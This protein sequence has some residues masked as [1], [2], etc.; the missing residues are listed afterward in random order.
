MRRAKSSY[1][2]VTSKQADTLSW[3]GVSHSMASNHLPG[4]LTKLCLTRRPP[5]YLSRSQSI[6]ARAASLED[7][8]LSTTGLSHELPSPP[9]NRL[10]AACPS[11]ADPAAIAEIR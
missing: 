11:D 1:A 3:V 8:T 6:S 10:S 4:S 5:P 2:F 9:E 7:R